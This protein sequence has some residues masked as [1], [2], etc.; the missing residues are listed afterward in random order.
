MTPPAA[1]S[2]AVVPEPEAP[3]AVAP[4][5]AAVATEPLRPAALKRLLPERVQTILLGIGFPIALV[6]LWHQLVVMTGTR[7]IPTPYQ[8]GLMMYDFAAGGIHDDA[9]SGTIL[10]HLLASM[11]RVY[12]GFAL[13]VVLGVPLGLIIGKVRIIRELVDP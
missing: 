8:V 10:T 12:G 5:A 7:L 11:G 9:F 13:A 3:E 2:I 4:P 6:L 1:A